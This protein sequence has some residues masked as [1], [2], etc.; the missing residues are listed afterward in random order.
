M[1]K[2]TGMYFRKNTIKVIKRKKY[3]LKRQLLR[4]KY[5]LGE[6]TPVC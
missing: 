3:N 5:S 6:I 2:N 1:F 4:S